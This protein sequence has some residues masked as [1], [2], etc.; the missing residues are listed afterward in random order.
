[1]EVLVHRTYSVQHSVQVGGSHIYNET[2]NKNIDIQMAEAS[3]IP[4]S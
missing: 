4:V 1:M 2:P 3:L